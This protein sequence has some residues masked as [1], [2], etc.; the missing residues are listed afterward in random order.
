MAQ[1]AVGSAAAVVD[2]GAA[3]A[4]AKAKYIKYKIKYMQLK[5]LFN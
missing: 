3:S 4:A 5:A 2:K 1:P